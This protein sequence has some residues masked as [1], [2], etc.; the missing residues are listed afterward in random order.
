MDLYFD[1]RDGE[2][3]Y[4]LDH[5]V[6]NFDLELERLLAAMLMIGDLDFRFVDDGDILFL[7]LDR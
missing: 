5:E 3:E 4:E 7:V 2:R 1:R 6:R